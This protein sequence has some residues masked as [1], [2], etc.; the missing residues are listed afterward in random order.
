MENVGIVYPVWYILLSFGTFYGHW[1]HFVVKWYIFARFGI[2]C[3]TNLAAPHG[4]IRFIES[5]PRS[6]IERPVGRFFFN[7]DE[8]QLNRTFHRLK[9]HIIITN[10]RLCNIAGNTQIKL[11]VAHF[12]TDSFEMFCE[13]TYLYRNYACLLLK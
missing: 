5:V 12:Q 10:I 3:K 9:G 1:I 6:V 11:L 13:L 4:R 7:C 8:Q 2:F